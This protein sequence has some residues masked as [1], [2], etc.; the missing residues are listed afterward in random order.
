MKMSIISLA[1]PKIKIGHSAAIES[2]DV[3]TTLL[4]QQ[5][6]LVRLFQSYCAHYAEEQKIIRI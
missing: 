6:N 4:V 2:G 3:S 1:F 5:Q